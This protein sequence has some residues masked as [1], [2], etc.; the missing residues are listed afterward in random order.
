M[1][2]ER[3]IAPV[4]VAV[5]VAVV[6][7][8][9]GLAYLLATW[10]AAEPREPVAEPQDEAIMDEAIMDAMADL[11]DSPSPASEIDDPAARSRTPE[12]PNGD[13]ERMTTLDDRSDSGSTAVDAGT[14]GDAP[15][16]PA[17]QL[18]RRERLLRGFIA[19]NGRENVVV[20]RVE[21]ADSL[22]PGELVAELRSKLNSRRA[23]A[24]PPGSDAIMAIRY[25]G[26]LDHV[27][28][29]ISWG[30]VTS[31]NPQRRLIR[32]DASPDS[33]TSIEPSR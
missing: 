28:E 24:T 9:S 25:D 7:M 10:P 17:R 16:Q 30:T 12:R 22:R 5:W 1:T 18:P 2:P 29:L 3:R 27:T 13:L 32:V 31:S 21:N 15:S 4:T 26:E 33:T 11:S 6:G 14:S 20:I 19:N 8:G 23:W